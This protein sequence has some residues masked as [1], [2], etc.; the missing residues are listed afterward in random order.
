[1]RGFLNRR[2]KLS[3]WVLLG[4]WPKV[5]RGRSHEIPLVPGRET[6]LYILLYHL[7][8]VN[9]NLLRYHK[10]KDNG[11]A[12]YGGR[13]HCGDRPPREKQL[14]GKGD[15]RRG[16]ALRDMVRQEY[17]DRVLRVVALDQGRT[18]LVLR[19]F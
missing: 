8:L 2:F 13:R 18:D 19:E 9:S 3:F 1:M 6:I 17:A 16:T 5:P 4:Q 12:A 14:S 10:G 11:R 15:H 7:L